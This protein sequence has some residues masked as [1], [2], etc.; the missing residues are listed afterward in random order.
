M[1]RSGSQLP[2][3]R[4]QCRPRLTSGTSTWAA[5]RAWA[6]LLGRERFCIRKRHSSLGS[7]ATES[8]EKE[9]T[10]QAEGRG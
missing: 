4:V 7:L 3:S 5:S 2:Q 6:V 8:R 10:G 1:A 9:D